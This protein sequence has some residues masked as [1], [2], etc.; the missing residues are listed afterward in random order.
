MPS[1]Y[2]EIE[3]RIERALEDLHEQQRPN[4]A[5]TAQRYS[6]PSKRLRNRWNNIPSKQDLNNKLPKLSPEQ[7]LALI[8]TLDR[9]DK[10]ELSARVPM[11]IS[12]ANGILARAH[13]ENT[14]PPTVS[15]SWG[16][17]WLARHPEFSVIKGK[18]LA[19]ARKS[20]HDPVNISRWYA[21]L[22]EI[23]TK[24]SLQPYDIINID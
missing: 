6:V 21:V 5:K 20:A 9:L 3:E 22:Q 10:C 1:N 15:V 14:P 19:M 7:D 12:I 16:I 11:L 18:T 13:L 17:R 23:I 2:S 24:H 8:H 4:L